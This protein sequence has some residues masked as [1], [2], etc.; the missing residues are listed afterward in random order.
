MP[1][2]NPVNVQLETCTGNPS[3]VLTCNPTPGVPAVLEKD[4]LWMNALNAPPGTFSMVMLL[5]LVVISGAVPLSP[6][7]VP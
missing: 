6:G 2:E 1:V 4:T 3:P 5:V 7:V